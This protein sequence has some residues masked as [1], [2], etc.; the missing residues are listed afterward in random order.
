MVFYAAG[1]DESGTETWSIDNV[2]LSI[3]YRSALD[4]LYLPLTQAS[5]GD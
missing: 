1:L 5:Q 3:Y 4:Y 2:H